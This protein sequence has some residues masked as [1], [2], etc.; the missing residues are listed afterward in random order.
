M[1]N[2]RM[3]ESKIYHD[4]LLLINPIVVYDLS[5]ELSFL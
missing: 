2:F 4:A 1:T 3:V 5:E